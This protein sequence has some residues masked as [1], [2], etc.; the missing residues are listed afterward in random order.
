MAVASLQQ[1]NHGTAGM[2]TND[3][4]R[5]EQRTLTLSLVSV[6]GIALMSFAWGLAI[7]SDVVIL[8][9]VF[10]LVSLIGSVLYL[11]AARLV[12]RPADHRFQFGYAHVEPLAAG[13]NGLLVL[14]IC[15]YALIN[16]VE[17]L[18]V[19]G[20]EVSP[21]GVVWFGA[22]SGAFCA[23][24]GGYEWLVARRTGSQLLRNDSREWLIDAAFS[25]V[26]LAGFAVLWLL[27][28]PWRA[29]WARHADSALVALLALLFIP[30]PLGVLRQNLREM[31]HMADADRELA[32]RVEAVMAEVAAEH[33]VASHS[34]HVAK[35]GRSSFVEVN[36]V[37]GPRFALQTVADQ[38]RLRE[39]VWQALGLAP[40]QGWLS[41]NITADP[42]WA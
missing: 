5:I 13:A 16:G 22:L 21:A 2:R 4:A 15:V 3:R 35:V 40:D 41:I 36:I 38:D 28:E 42:R 39:R 32:M 7:E 27:D 25:L 11:T 14:V 30:V 23:A 17:G 8:N 34:T 18:R 1:W 26:T 6:A 20:D 24:F 29:W 10:S 9:G 33:D 31:L 37:A 12:N 19:G